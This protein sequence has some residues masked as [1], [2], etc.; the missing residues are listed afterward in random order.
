[1][2]SPGSPIE[3]VINNSGVAILYLTG[4]GEAVI[5]RGITTNSSGRLLIVVNGSV[6]ITEDPGTSITA[7]TP[8]MSDKPNIMAG[9]IASGTIE[10]E[11][12]GTADKDNFDKAIMFTAPFISRSGLTF[13]RDLYHD[14][15]ATMPAE[16]AKA[17]NK[18]LYL[19]TSLEREESADNLYFTGLTTFDIDWE[20]IY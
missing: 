1:M 10:I 7:T 19:L 12:Q 11:S 9:I 3:Y 4:G 17:F 16:S 2:D 13:S 20:Y 15:N 6:R 14:N 8:T 18:Y 5:A